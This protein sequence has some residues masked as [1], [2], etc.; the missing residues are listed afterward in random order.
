[1]SP[2]KPTTSC[3]AKRSVSIKVP[4]PPI[5]IIGWSLVLQAWT[6]TCFTRTRPPP[7]QEDF[8]LED[9]RQNCRLDFWIVLCALPRICFMLGVFKMKSISNSQKHVLALC[10]VARCPN[11]SGGC[12]C[13]EISHTSF[14]HFSRDC[15]C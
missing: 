12:A 11:F 2:Q 13:G 7:P 1:M 10:F 8:C 6:H 14:Y 5:R 9:R 15:L 4:T 3:R